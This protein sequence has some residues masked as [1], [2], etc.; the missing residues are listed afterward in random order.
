ML[1][2]LDGDGPLYMRVYDA[3]CSE[4]R[5]GRLK[6]GKR[7]PG[8]RTLARS[9]GVS[10]TVILQAYAQLDSEGITESAMR[11]GTYVRAALLHPVAGNDRH[12]P[13]L[14]TC[15]APIPVSRWAELAL[16]SLPAITTTNDPDTADLINLAD[17][18]TVQDE[19]G[20]R[21]WRHALIET[22]NAR[23]S[24][25]SDAFG[26]YALRRALADYL[27]DERGVFVD[28]DDLLIVNG[29]Q[30]AR[31]MV[32]RVLAEAGTVVGV[33]DPGYRGVPFAFSAMGARIIP[34]EM[35]DDG[36]DI[37]RHAD[38]LEDARVICVM[39]AHHFPTGA[40]MSQE[41]RMAL[42]DWSSRHS[43]YIVEDDF[44]YEHCLGARVMP[45]LY[46]LASRERVIYMG[47]FARTHLPFMRLAYMVVPHQLRKYFLA[48]KRLADR[49]TELSSQ[50][51]QARYIADG[52]Y[53]RNLRRLAGPLQRRRELLVDALQRHLGGL[54]R[55]QGVDNGGDLL[56]HL[57]A[58]PSSQTQAFLDAAALCGLRLQ[59]ADCY[60]LRPCP[61]LTLLLR[62]ASVPEQRIGEAVRRLAQTCQSMRCPIPDVRPMTFV[63]GLRSA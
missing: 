25:P 38:T 52:D 58:I 62:Y 19:R 29:I 1:L 49:G 30:Q 3:L 34:C 37:E 46:A 40:V 21:L 53:V 17:M 33:G 6:V 12:P 18:S 43:V 5:E 36:F 59:S 8:T 39:P 24:D 44:D 16:A 50:Q 54:A 45:P 61:H 9:L 4:I 26:L 57:P 32:A 7:L 22:V 51:A 31:D 20:F 47:S 28:P 11:K 15:A 2:T 41:R 23:S 63:P 35:D 13:P 10:R 48:V 14:A 55:F 42:L 56:L 27:H 60:Y